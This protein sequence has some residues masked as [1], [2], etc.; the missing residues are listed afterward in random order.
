MVATALA[1]VAA[2][3]RFANSSAASP[4]PM[5][6]TS[7][8]AVSVTPSKAPAIVKPVRTVQVFGASGPRT[9]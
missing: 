3:T 2:L 6:R 4:S 7:D 8:P 9:R 5:L 1:A